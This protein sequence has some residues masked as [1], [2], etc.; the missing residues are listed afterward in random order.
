MV[1]YLVGGSWR[2]DLQNLFPQIFQ[3][4]IITKIELLENL[5][6][7]GIYYIILNY[8]ILVDLG[9]RIYKN[10]YAHKYKYCMIMV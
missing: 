1:H 7:Y 8:Y 9:Y 2:T 5:V 3:K 10:T 4:W 6:L